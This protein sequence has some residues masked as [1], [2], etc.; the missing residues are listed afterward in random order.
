MTNLL[1]NF[2]Q[3]LRKSQS[4]RNT[5]NELSRLTDRELAD[6]GIA[7]GDIKN[8]ARGDQSF[9]LVSDYNQNLKG[10]V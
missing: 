5:F 4:Y 3:K 6:I 9:K 10:W 2:L 7:R 8:V 1:K